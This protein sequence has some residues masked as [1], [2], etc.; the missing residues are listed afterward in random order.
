MIS[1]LKHIRDTI[2]MFKNIWNKINYYKD[3]VIISCY[4]KLYSF[5]NFSIY[6]FNFGF[7][8]YNCIILSL[9]FY[10]IFTFKVLISV[11]K[12]S[13]LLI[14]LKKSSIFL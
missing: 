3:S 14:N 6:S 12:C 13:L 9:I 8:F 11:Y 10:L 5:F 2:L 1:L 4:S 7:L